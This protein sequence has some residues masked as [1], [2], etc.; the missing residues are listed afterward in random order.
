MYRFLSICLLAC[1]WGLPTLGQSLPGSR[2]NPLVFADHN[3][4]IRQQNG[5][6]GI[7]DSANFWLSNS[8]KGDTAFH[9]GNRHFA[10][11]TADGLYTLFDEQFRMEKAHLS[12][13]KLFS[14][15]VFLK[16]AKGWTIFSEDEDSKT[17]YYDSIRIAGNS[18]LLYKGG[19]QGLLYLND[20]R[21]FTIPAQ[22]DKAGPYYEGVLLIDHGKLG[23][24]G[25]FDIPVAYD[26]IYQERPDMMAAQ[27]KE[28]TVYYSYDT[29]KPLAAEPGDSIVFYDRCYKRVRGRIQS[30][31][32][33]SDNSLVAEIGGEQ[34]HPYS[35]E[36]AYRQS[37]YCV[38]GRDTAC[39]LYRNGKQLTEFSYRNILP[40]SSIAPPFFR[41]LQKGGVGVILENGE[42]QLSSQYTDV[43]NRIGNY[44]IVRRGSGLGLVSVGDTVLLPCEYRNITFCNGTY[45]YLSKDGTHFALYNYITRK[46]ISPYKYRD[47]WIDRTFIIAKQT[48]TGDI[49]YNDEALMSDVYDA[50]VNG[51]T[52][53]GYK[54]GKIYIGSVGK[55]G[56][57][58]YEYEIPSY[59][60]KAE[61]EYQHFL[62]STWLNDSDDM[63]DYASGKWGVFSYNTGN[64]SSKPLAHGGNDPHLC[65]LLDFPSDSALS[66]QGLNFYLRK[67]ISPISVAWQRKSK[68]SWIDTHLYNYS[69]NDQELTTIVVS[70]LC[71]T[72][73]G[74]GRCLKNY[75]SA[76][77][78]TG[79][80]TYTNKT[81][82]AES[83]RVKV[84]SYGQIGLS[85]FITQ[86]SSSGN[87]HPAGLKDYETL[88][89]PRLFVSISGA[90]EHVLQISNRVKH[91]SA[92]SGFEWVDPEHL[93]PV[94]CRVAG[95]Y[96][97]LSDTGSYLL[98]PEYE[99]LDPIGG[100][101][102]AMYQV[103]VRGS[104]YRLYY[105]ESNTYSKEIKQLLSFKGPYLLIKA[106]ST[107]LAVLDHRLDT[108]L[109]SSGAIT[110]L[111]DSGYVLKKDGISYIYKKRRLLFSHNGDATEKIN[112][113]HYLISNSRGQY[114]LSPKGD[115]IYQSKQ[116]I[117]YVPLGN[118]YLIDS[119][120]DRTV[121]DLS[122]KAVCRFEK[123]PYLVTDKKHLIVKEKE[124]VVL[125]KKNGTNQVR[126]K[127]RYTKATGLYV[128]TRNPKNKQVYDYSGSL[129]VSKALKVKAI[130]ERY[131]SYQLGKKFTLYDVITGEK[132]PIERLGVS[133]S[134]EG[135]EY[136]GSDEEDDSTQVVETIEELYSIVSYK[137]KYGLKKEEKLIL[138]YNFFHIQKAD[139]VFLVQDKIEYKL[140]DLFSNTFIT[141]DSYESVYPYKFSFQVWK[142]GKMYYINR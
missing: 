47:F 7:G 111:E 28:G 104:S 117:R 121:F 56:W 40:E 15:Y 16:E 53:K 57:E 34:I 120:Q 90:T 44:Y 129:L 81:L 77:I 6:Y 132:R 110:L 20:M 23:W 141:N 65:R 70:P 39:A 60:V 19:K 135:L 76:V 21:E 4:F 63:Y 72:E 122:D 106:D 24:Q 59:K 136:D 119:G 50:E 78:N 43:L 26:H 140:Y 66:W 64:W 142:D 35:F 38:I 114:I 61:K 103:G 105:P 127:G 41:V 74:A 125:L 27:N 107:R 12:E 88:I 52:A 37:E 69:A 45:L 115:T 67:K 54:N 82:L 94:I 22:Y 123:E 42:V 5:V 139:D 58:S 71:Y 102:A 85:A 84:G 98:K 55:T 33:I 91:I 49:Y 126:V 128:I 133:I 9:V 108:L 62:E 138:P 14:H 10:M 130:N 131:F 97:L 118:N 18:V 2:G 79:F 46:V 13:L 25:A 109:I 83:G 99:S 112:E 113:G 30:I 32:R 95:K 134:K 31:F 3:L 101:G 68:Y 96:G 124:S 11:R 51:Q 75:P 36:I 87:I 17:I 73:P 137:G 8:P 1:S 80:P 29:G 89:D 48:T 93:N 116:A 86:M 100:Y 92:Q